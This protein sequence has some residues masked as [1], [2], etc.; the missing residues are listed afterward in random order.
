MDSAAHHGTHRRPVP[1][2]NS[3]TASSARQGCPCRTGLATTR[4]QTASQKGRATSTQARGSPDACLP[5]DGQVRRVLH[6]GRALDESVRRERLLL[7]P[8]ELGPSCLQSVRDGP[9][10]PARAVKGAPR[11]R[12]SSAPCR[13]CHGWSGMPP[14]P[15]PGAP[16]DGSPSG[17][18]A[19]NPDA[20]ATPVPRRGRRSRAG[21]RMT[22]SLCSPRG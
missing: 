22:C 19:L 12:R 18:R 16:E 1:S 10:V 4:G 13:V 2:E 15:S 9:G 3:G 17:L 6:P 7:A 14:P 8:Q 21:G 20:A 5:E 11:W